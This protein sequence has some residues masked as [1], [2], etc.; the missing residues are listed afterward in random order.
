MAWDE[1]EQLKA[2]HGDRGSTAVQLD[3]RPAE[4]G[5]GAAGEA[6]GLRHS[7]KPWTRAAVTA[8]HL[9]TDTHKARGDLSQ[10][11]AGMTAGLTGLASLAELRTVLDSWEK[12]LDS[13]RDECRSL[14]PKLRQVAADL[15]GV[16]TATGAKSDAVHTPT[17]DESR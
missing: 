8:E 4:A 6:G 12:R 17:K 16:D 7:A 13:V 9:G 14:A 10:G 11:H 2:T 1:W 15:G 3:Q 5:G